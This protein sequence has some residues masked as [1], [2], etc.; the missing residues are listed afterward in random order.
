[1]K[2]FKNLSLRNISTQPKHSLPYE[3]FVTTH[4]FMFWKLQNDVW[5][6]LPSEKLYRGLSSLIPSILEFDICPIFPCLKFDPGPG[7]MDLRLGAMARYVPFL[8]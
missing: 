7:S 2:N 5:T 1:M 3:Y 8:I 4:L 6:S